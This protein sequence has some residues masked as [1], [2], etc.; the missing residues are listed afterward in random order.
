MAKRKKHIGNEQPLPIGIINDAIIELLETEKLDKENLLLKT[1]EV[2]HGDN[3]AK[4]AANAI[5]SVVTKKSALNKALLSNFS[6]ETY[7][8]LS[9]SDKNTIV[10]SLICVRFPFTFDFMFSLSKLFNVQDTVNKQYINEKM[11]SLYG[12]NLSLEHGIEAALATV[13]KCG[14]IKREKP[15]LFSK[16]EPCQKSSFAK[17]AWIATFFELNGKKTFGVNDLNYEPVMSY[18]SDLNVDWDNAKILEISTD[19]SNQM[20]ISKLK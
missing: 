14:F 4:K 17:E 6:P 7:Y 2:Y 10:I 3:R 19:Y 13:I 5:Y 20:I 16:V 8:R 15:G 12:S 18:L 9:E 1:K 11:A